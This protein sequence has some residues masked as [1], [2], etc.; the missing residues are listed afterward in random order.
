MADLLQPSLGE[1]LAEWARRVRADAE[2][3]ERQGEVK[4]PPDFYAPVA[5]A[6]RADPHRQDDVA[7]NLVRAL[8]QP[9]DVWLDIGAGGGRF[10]LQLALITKEV[11]AVEP[12]EGMLNVLRDG[13]REHGISNIRIIQE[14][15][16]VEP[17]PADVAMIAH[18]GNDVEEIGPFIDAMERAARR[19]CVIVNWFRAPRAI[20][21]SLWEPIYGEPR[22]T[23]PAL[24]EFFALLLAR[25]REFEVRL[26]A[27]PPMSFEG[28]ADAQP[29]IRRGLWLEQGSARDQHLSRL[30][31]EVMTERDGRFAASWDPMTIAAVSWIP[32]GRR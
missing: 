10:T 9:D 15:W 28:A 7:L 20:A 31:D 14:R 26:A 30:L 13:M 25:G 17:P 16:P 29:F 12:S 6:F 22:A 23:L 18:V 1:V 21:D 5:S 32:E 2:Q 3:V 8:A 4:T 27:R 24:P 19:L 11:I